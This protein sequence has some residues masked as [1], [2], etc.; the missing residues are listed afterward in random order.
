[1]RFQ[2]V[3]DVLD[4]VIIYHSELAAE[5]RKLAPAVQD[6]RVGKLLGYLADHEDQQRVGLERYDESD[7][8]R[9]VLDTWLQNAPDLRHIKKLEE[10]KGC[11]C[12]TS[13]DDVMSLAGKIHE[14]LG[15][16]Y[17]TLAVS[18]AIGDEYDLFNSL[19]EFQLVENRRLSR[20]AGTLEM[21]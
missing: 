8:H 11:A 7:E 17:R 2:Q 18:A 14:T 21:Y 15:D 16:M 20:D 5:Y 6:E 3:R 4:H 13:M 1:M 19:A 12:C 10:L 9:S